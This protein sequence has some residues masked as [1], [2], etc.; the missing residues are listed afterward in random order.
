MPRISK[1]TLTGPHLRVLLV[2]AEGPLR[3]SDV[4]DRAELETEA[5]A[6]RYLKDL[7]R[8][9]L[10]EEERVDIRGDLGVIETSDVWY[11]ITEAGEMRCQR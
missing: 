5:W 6:V 10:L 4:A 11:R 9:G 3:I 8:W 2:L 7:A 1:Q